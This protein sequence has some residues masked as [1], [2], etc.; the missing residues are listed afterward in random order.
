MRV[1]DQ[2]PLVAVA[3][4]SESGR[5]TP[6]V[7]TRRRL[8]RVRDPSEGELVGTLH[9]TLDPTTERLRLHTLAWDKRQNSYQAVYGKKSKLKISPQG[10]ATNS[11][12]VV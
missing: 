12:F 6:P 11:N 1:G 10:V 7:G 2:R 3:Q 9:Q 8:S 5:V 4:V